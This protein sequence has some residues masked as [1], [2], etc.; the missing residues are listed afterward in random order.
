MPPW[1]RSDTDFPAGFSFL[2]CIALTYQPTMTLWPLHEPLKRGLNKQVLSLEE[3]PFQAP[4][5]SPFR[6]DNGGELAPVA[7]KYRSVPL[8]GEQ[9]LIV[10]CE[11]RRSFHAH[12]RCVRGCAAPLVPPTTIRCYLSICPDVIVIC[13]TGLG[14]T[15]RDVLARRWTPSCTTRAP[16]SCCL[17]RPSTS[18]IPSACAANHG[19]PSVLQHSGT[20]AL[21]SSCL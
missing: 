18:S 10:R 2:K 14:M 19:H 16:T 11:V 13:H 1:G 6:G 21:L 17:S 3:K 9:T 8:G 12:T 4:E 7:H 20:S 5:P 15:G